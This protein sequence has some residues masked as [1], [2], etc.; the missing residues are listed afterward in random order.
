MANAGLH[1]F[2]NTTDPCYS[3][4]PADDTS[5]TGCSL[6]NIDSFV[7]WNNVHPTGAVQALWAQGMEQAVPEPST[8]ATLIIGFAGTGLMGLR[9]A[10][11][12][13]AA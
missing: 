1:G 9:S 2:T 5:A 8:W 12:R 6:S 3:N 13:R 10:R 4:A 7:Y 11:K